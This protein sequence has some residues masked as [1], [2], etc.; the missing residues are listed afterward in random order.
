MWKALA[1]PDRILLLRWEVWADKT[2]LT[3][4]LFIGVHVPN[5]ESE[6]SC[7]WNC[8][9]SVVFLLFVLFLLLTPRHAIL[10]VIHTM[11]IIIRSNTLRIIFVLTMY[12]RQSFI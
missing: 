4:S 6:W 12:Q 9:D 5:K 1:L 11:L 7:I 8:S 3:P 10:E 2:S